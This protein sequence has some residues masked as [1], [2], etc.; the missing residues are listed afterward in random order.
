ME[1][2]SYL[3]PTLQCNN[4]TNVTFIAVS[5]NQNGEGGTSCTE[6]IT[7]T[8][9]EQLFAIST[10]SSTQG[11]V[12][13]AKLKCYLQANDLSI[14]VQTDWSSNNNNLDDAIT[15][16]GSGKN[17]VA[18]IGGLSFNHGAYKISVNSLG[19]FV[20]EPVNSGDMPWHKN[21]T[22][23]SCPSN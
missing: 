12:D 21:L 7:D 11:A 17:S 10:E 5:G 13:T 18:N 8:I 9:L 23:Y 16:T 22:N 1:K 20:F 4:I 6:V 15:V 3:K 14:N 19:C 2:R